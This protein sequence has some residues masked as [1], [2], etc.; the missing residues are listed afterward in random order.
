M[1]EFE[2]GTVYHTVR[3]PSFV[4]AGHIGL[5]E[6]TGNVPTDAEEGIELIPHM[7]G[8]SFA[9]EDEGIKEEAGP[10]LKIDKG[11]GIISAGIGGDAAAIAGTH[12]AHGRGTDDA[13]DDGGPA[14]VL[15]EVPF[16]Q[17]GDLEIRLDDG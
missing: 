7:A 17:V 4:G 6:D 1:E 13:F 9:V 10:L 2:K 16:Q 5:D 3:I 14:A 8:A 11:D 12:G 15:F